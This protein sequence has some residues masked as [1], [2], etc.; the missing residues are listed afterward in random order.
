M[1][2]GS[3]SEEIDNI[4]ACWGSPPTLHPKLRITHPT[5]PS[6]DMPACHAASPASLRLEVHLDDALFVDAFELADL[7]GPPASTFGRLEGS[8]GIRWRLQPEVQDLERPILQGLRVDPT[9]STRG[10]SLTLDVNLQAA[11]SGSRG[12]EGNGDI[13]VPLHSRYL[14][15]QKGESYVSLVVG[16]HVNISG[17]WVCNESNGGSL[18]RSA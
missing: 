12:Q 3:A 13:L 7:W 15:P 14:E 4:H 5:Q 17:Q 9:G 6:P 16:Q 10:G 1:P 8:A 11:K 2:S 18:N